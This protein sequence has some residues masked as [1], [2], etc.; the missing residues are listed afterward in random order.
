M[1][2][3]PSGTFYVATCYGDVNLLNRD[4]SDFGGG[5]GGSA[6]AH[7]TTGNLVGTVA[8]AAVTFAIID[9]FKEIEQKLS[10]SLAAAQSRTYRTEFEEH[11]IA[12]KRA[13]KAIE[14]AA[15]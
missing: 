4:L 14:A 2:Y 13:Y 11:H 1:C 9:W 10:K 12:A 15:I 3:D 8:G 6:S 5:G 7:S